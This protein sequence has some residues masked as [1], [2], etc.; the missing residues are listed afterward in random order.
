[1]LGEEE[2]QNRLGYHKPVASDPNDEP[3]TTILHRNL[4]AMFQEVLRELD[5]QLP[6]GRPKS[7][8]FTEFETM[9]M[10]AHK[11]VAQLDPVSDE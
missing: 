3:Y 5:N 8:C 11:S 6:E 1:M 7:V 9:A 10:W 2:I 4:R